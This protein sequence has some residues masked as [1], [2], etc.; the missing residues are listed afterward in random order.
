MTRPRQRGRRLLHLTVLACVF[1]SFKGLIGGGAYLWLGISG[2]SN[3]VNPA[4]QGATL[5]LILLTFLR[6]GRRLARL[7]RGLLVAGG[8]L[9]VPAVAMGDFAYASVV[10]L[11]L[12]VPV[13]LGGVRF[14]DDRFVRRAVGSFFVLTILYV[15]VEDVLLHAHLYGLA[16]EPVVSEQAIRDFYSQ[17][18]FGGTEEGRIEIAT[19]DERYGVIDVQDRRIRSSGFLGHPLQMPALVAMGATYFF[20][21]WRRARSVRGLFWVVLGA[22]SLFNTLSTTSVTAFLV[23]VV[24]YELAQRPG[25]RKYAVVVGLGLVV[26]GLVIRVNALQYLLSRFLFHLERGDHRAFLPGPEWW[27][28]PVLL[29]IGRHAWASRNAVW[30]ENDLLNIV[31]AFGVVLAA[32]ILFRFVYPAL[33]VRRIRN[34]DLAVYSFVVLT[35]VLC[36]GHRESVSTPNVF[37][38]VTVLNTKARDIVRQACPIAVQ[39][40]PALAAAPRSA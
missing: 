35:A 3:W 8:V 6:Y 32:I 2:L 26:V 21:C 12:V 38:L 15:A 18:A 28:N 10:V 24:L 22:L 17:L 37:L 19:S 9:M 36:L 16:P 23:A 34:D 29:I 14:A 39:Y 4:V 11:M 30:S 5:L 40:R 33:E 20:I 1:Y 31:S 27:S 25:I 13:L 7:D